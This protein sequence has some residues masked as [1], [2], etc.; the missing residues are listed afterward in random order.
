MIPQLHAAGIVF[1]PL[2]WSSDG[3][4][5][6]AVSRT[7]KFAAE[8]AARK[9]GGVSVPNLLRRWRH[10]IQIAILRRRAAMLRAMQPKVGAKEA[11]LRTGAPGDGGDDGGARLEEVEEQA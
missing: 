6:P 3:R 7:L 2:I 4:P 5:H 11:W 10:E 9:R 1:R 8:S